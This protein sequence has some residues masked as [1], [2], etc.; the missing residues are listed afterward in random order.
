MTWHDMT[1]QWHDT[2]HM[3]HYTWHMTYDTTCVHVEGIADNYAYTMYKWRLR[4]VGICQVES[5]TNKI[6]LSKKFRNHNL[7]TPNWVQIPA[8]ITSRSIPKATKLSKTAQ[9][10]KKS[11]FGGRVPHHARQRESKLPPQTMPIEFKIKSW[12]HVPNIIEF[13]YSL[14]LPK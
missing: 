4:D 13:R 10:S 8:K 12:H 3:K 11:I 9:G 1:W 7:N 6:I 14:R 2:W 5:A